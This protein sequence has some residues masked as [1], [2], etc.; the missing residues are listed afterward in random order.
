[1]APHCMGEDDSK[2]NNHNGNGNDDNSD[3]SD[4]FKH[5]CTYQCQ[6]YSKS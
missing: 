5:N 3:N 6:Y 2:I 1:M 4:N